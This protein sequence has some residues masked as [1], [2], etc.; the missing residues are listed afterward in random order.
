M[1]TLFLKLTLSETP[2]LRGNFVVEVAQWAHE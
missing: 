1:S 2:R